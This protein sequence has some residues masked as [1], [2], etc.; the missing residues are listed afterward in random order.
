MRVLTG[1]E[2]L[3]PALFRNPVATIG[4]FDGMHLGHRAVIDAVRDLSREVSGE[5]VA[6]TF[7]SHP[8]L[9]LSG[10]APAPITSVGHRLVL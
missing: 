7:E 1:F 2:A 9:V 6:V 4:I 3:D 5:S 10:E 8:R